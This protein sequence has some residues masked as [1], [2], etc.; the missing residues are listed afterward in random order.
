MSEQVV[1]GFIVAIVFGQP[2]LAAL[3]PTTRRMI[4]I[5]S[6]FGSLQLIMGIVFYMLL[7]SAGA[8]WPWAFVVSLIGVYNLWIAWGLYR[9]RQGLR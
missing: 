5:R 7:L 8:V 3:F 1:V 6:V 4:S 9:A 2:I